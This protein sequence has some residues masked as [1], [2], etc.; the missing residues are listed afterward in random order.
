RHSHHGAELVSRIEGLD[1][2]VPWIRHSHESFDG[3]GY[4]DGLSGDAIPRAS[5]ILL[6]ADA[7]DA[8]TSTRPYRQARSVADAREELMRHAQQRGEDEPRKARHRRVGH[9]ALDQVGGEARALLHVDQER[10]ALDV[11]V[12]RRV[13]IA[14]GDRGHGYGLLEG[15]GTRRLEICPDPRLR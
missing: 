11:L 7:F 12:D 15:L 5:R 4:P 2:I 9:A 14:R 6:V 13:D 3:S 8:I 10:P 1:R